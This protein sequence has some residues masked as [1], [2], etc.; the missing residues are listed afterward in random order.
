MSK[1]ADSLFPGTHLLPGDQGPRS[2]GAWQPWRG[3]ARGGFAQRRPLWAWAEGRGYQF[4]LSPRGRV[5]PVRDN[6][7]CHFCANL[8]PKVSV[9][10]WK[11]MDGSKSWLSWDGPA[12]S[13]SRHFHHLSPLPACVLLPPSFS[14]M[15][16][17]GCL[18]GVFTWMCHQRGGFGRH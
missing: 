16:P 11:Q 4:L 14:D 17:I 1:T 2:R 6:T 12:H 15:S 9:H 8:L 10:P 3:G 7:L 18:L 5:W 13:D